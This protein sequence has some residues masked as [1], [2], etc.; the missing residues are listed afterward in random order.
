MSHIAK[1]RRVAPAATHSAARARIE[2]ENSMD[3]RTHHLFD[4]VAGETTRAGPRFY[5]R[6]CGCRFY[7]DQQVLQAERYGCPGC[8]RVNIGTVGEGEP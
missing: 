7:T 8:D 4:E 6:V 3:D 2:Q 1:N 5:C